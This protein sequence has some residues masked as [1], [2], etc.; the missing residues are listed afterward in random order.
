MKVLVTGAA[1]FIGRHVCAAL[2][3]Q[4]HDVTAVYRSTPPIP[5]AGVIWEAADLTQR[6]S[7]QRL[8]PGQDAIVHLA[9]RAHVMQE[10]G[11]AAAAFAQH[12]LRPVR[13]MLEAMEDATPHVVLVSSI[14]VNGDETQGVPFTALDKPNPTEPYAVSKLQAETCLREMATHRGVPWTV[15]RPPLVYGADAPGNFARLVR[16]A[17]SGLPLPLR[18]VANRRSLISVQHL[19]VFMGRVIEDERAR[20][21]I[22]LLSDNDVDVSTGAIVAALRTGM[23]QPERLFRLPAG[24][25][26]LGAKLIGRERLWR[27]LTGSLQIDASAMLDIGFEPALPTL[28][29]LRNIGAELS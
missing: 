20:G 11:D 9:G 15:V 10:R 14:G 13:L 2:Q 6:S 24:A 28:E 4:G 27:K 7:W 19:A 3:K 22:Y 23:G 5:G 18:A 17:R 21:Q 8:L 16:L 26:A 29:A 12:N 1:G 25:L